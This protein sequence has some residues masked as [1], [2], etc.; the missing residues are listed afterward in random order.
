MSRKLRRYSWK[1][2]AMRRVY[3]MYVWTNN[4]DGTVLVRAV[5]FGG[6]LTYSKELSRAECAD[7]LRTVRQFGYVIKRQFAGE[8]AA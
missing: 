1:L 2:P 8:Q 3:T 4:R 7:L 6:K 5:T